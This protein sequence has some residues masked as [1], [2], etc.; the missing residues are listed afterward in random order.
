[1]IIH[2]RYTSSVIISI[3]NE[4]T[5][6]V[7]HSR[8]F[9]APEKY[10][11]GHWLSE[12]WWGSRSLS[13]ECASNLQ[14]SSDIYCLRKFEISSAWVISNI[15]HWETAAAR[16]NCHTLLTLSSLFCYF[17]HRYS[18]RAT[19]FSLERNFYFRRSRV[20]QLSQSILH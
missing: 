11:T 19:L 20:Q 3:G 10:A 5:V 12:N 16:T 2:V 6:F 8:C 1:M 18:L 15:N 4:H 14:R 17:T 7:K 9:A 13:A